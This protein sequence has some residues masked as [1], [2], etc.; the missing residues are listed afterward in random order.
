MNIRWNSMSTKM[1]ENDRWNISLKKIEKM[2][3]WNY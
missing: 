1:T 3:G 2:I